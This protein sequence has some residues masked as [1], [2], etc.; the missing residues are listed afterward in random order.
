MINARSRRG[1]QGRNQ[2]DDGGWRLER[3]AGRRAYEDGKHAIEM[4]AS[5]AACKEVFGS[6]GK[7]QQ[8]KLSAG[9]FYLWSQR[10]NG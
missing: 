5:H 2:C 6:P 8:K 1:R 10:L 4:K 3:G 7:T 9:M